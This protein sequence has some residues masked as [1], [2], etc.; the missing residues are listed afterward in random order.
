MLENEERG[1][2]FRIISHYQ[3]PI[4]L[5]H[6]CCYSVYLGKTRGHK[7]KQEY[8][9]LYLTALAQASWLL[10][11]NKYISLKKWC[12]LS[13]WDP[14]FLPFMD[15]CTACSWCADSAPFTQHSAGFLWW[16]LPS[17]LLECLIH[18]PS[19]FCHILLWLI[20]TYHFLS[21]FYMVP[22]AD[23]Q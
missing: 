17:S 1:V 23:K 19:L 21:S 2:C 9:N 8:P 22:R 15:G 4:F 12:K 6:L 5:H 7:F 13:T 18:T 20:L 16:Y 3:G 11:Y 10:M 14:F